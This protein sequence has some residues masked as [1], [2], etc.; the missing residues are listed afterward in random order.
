MKRVAALILLMLYFGASTGAT[1]HYHFCMGEMASFSFQQNEEEIC[2]TCGMEKNVSEESGCCTDEQ[3]WIKI[4]DDQK[5]S[6]AFFDASNVPLAAISFII[7]YNNVFTAQ[8][9]SPFTESK[10]PLRSWQLPA[11]LLNRVF[12]I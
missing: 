4:E 9:D 2:G 7:L 6:A 12:R 8:D 10:A 3:Q 11:Y 5:A 1:I